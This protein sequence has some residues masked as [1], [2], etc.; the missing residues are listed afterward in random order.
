MIQNFIDTFL[1]QAS[2]EMI[3]G[4]KKFYAEI[5]PLRGVWATGKTLEECRTNLLSAL[6]GWL[7]FRLR[8][9]LTVPHFKV[10]T[11]LKTQRQRAYA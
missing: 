8:N 7:I 5:K 1:S 9:R 10:P 4:G 6:E 11:K 3:D 2:Y